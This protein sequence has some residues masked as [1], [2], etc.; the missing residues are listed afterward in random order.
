[1]PPR[2]SAK[3]ARAKSARDLRRADQSR[4]ALISA[5]ATPRKLPLSRASTARAAASTPNADPAD[6]VLKQSATSSRCPARRHFEPRPLSRG[7]AVAYAMI[8]NKADA[9]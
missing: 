8:P 7:S 9:A 1:M 2:E 4:A 3:A 6:A 5:E